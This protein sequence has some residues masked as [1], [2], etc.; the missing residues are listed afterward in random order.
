MDGEEYFDRFRTAEKEKTQVVEV[1][2]T[3]YRI[4]E[5]TNAYVIP[6]PVDRDKEEEYIREVEEGKGKKR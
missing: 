2:Y 6:F 3:E 5:E 1:G 4:T